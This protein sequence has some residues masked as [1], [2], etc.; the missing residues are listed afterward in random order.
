MDTSYFGNIKNIDNPLSISLK[1]PEWYSGSEFKVLAPTYNIISR[2][3]KHEIDS[4][5]YIELFNDH[6]LKNLNPLD[7]YNN[8][9]NTY[10]LNVSLICYEKPGEFCHRHLISEWFNINLGTNICEWSG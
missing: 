10:G 9:V 5:V 4:K 1:A 6:V 8:I 7:V 2:Y 3:K